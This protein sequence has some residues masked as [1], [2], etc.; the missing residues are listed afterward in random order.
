[1]FRNAAPWHNQFVN[2]PTNWD[3]YYD[4]PFPASKVTRRFLFDWLKRR[5]HEAFPQPDRPLSFL[6]LGGGNSCFF[7]GLSRAFPMSRYV[8][9]DSNEKSLRLFA[10]RA[11]ALRPGIPT[12]SIKVNLATDDPAGGLP[13]ADVVFSTGLVEHF[14]PRLTSHVV[15]THFRCSTKK[16]GLVMITAPTPTWLYRTVRSCSELLGLW[17][18]PDERPLRDSEIL[19]SV[20]PTH[21]LTHS[22]VIWP[23]ILTQHGMAWKRTEDGREA[24]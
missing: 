20:P 22:G 6:E 17:A 11:A 24:A 15:K 21:A 4:A 5:I 12:Q 3:R 1:M 2:H 16:G 18:F 14:A 7:A 19:E 9:A 10:R 8:V 13:G 23:L